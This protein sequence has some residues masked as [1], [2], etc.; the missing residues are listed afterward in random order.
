MGRT[1]LELSK[2]RRRSKPSA[3]ARR[4]IDAAKSLLESLTPGEI[5]TRMLLDKADVA[6]NTLYLHFEDH[7]ALLEIA[8][9]EIFTEGVKEHMTLL[10]D[11]LNKSTSKNDF[12]RRVGHV[13][14]ISQDR[15]RRSFRITRCRLIAHSD[16]NPR[17]ASL[18][19]NEQA[20]INKTCTAFFIELRRRGWM[21]RSI[22]PESAAIIVQALTLGRVIDDVAADRLPQASWNEA[23]MMIVKEV[24]LAR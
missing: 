13:I 9:L 19:A 4:L 20:R 1:H 17:F 3:A 7:T 22:T 11:S 5:T 8:L 6:R 12:I 2:S 18:L 15:K 16:K 24:I 14:E 10:A 23:F 21:G